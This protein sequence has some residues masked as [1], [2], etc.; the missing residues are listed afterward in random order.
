MTIR[1]GILARFCPICNNEIPEHSNFCPSCGFKLIEATQQISPISIEELA[2]S[3]KGGKT[4]EQASLRIIRGPQIGSIYLLKDEDLT[5]GRRPQCDI[6]LND[7]TVSRLHATIHSIGRGFEI[8]DANSFNGLWINGKNV[9]SKTLE[10][11]DVIQIGTF[12]LVFEEK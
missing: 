4:F 8:M 1:G 3:D 6:F 7:T 5:V 11:G 10:P 9:E 2:T 12:C